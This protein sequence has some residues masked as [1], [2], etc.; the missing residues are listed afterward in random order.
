MGLMRL[1]GLMGRMG[2][3]MGS[4]KSNVESRMSPLGRGR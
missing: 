1:M 2:W 4:R 3:E